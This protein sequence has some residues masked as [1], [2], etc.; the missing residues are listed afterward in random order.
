MHTG[1]YEQQDKEHKKI[2]AVW[3]KSLRRF[4]AFAGEH[5]ALH[6]AERHAVDI[7]TVYQSASFGSTVRYIA[8]QFVDKTE[9]NS[10]S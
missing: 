3:E 9:A 5:A 1:K 7:Y 2:S 8:L 6:S 4:T 10:A